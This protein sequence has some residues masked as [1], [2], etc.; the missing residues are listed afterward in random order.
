MINH[1]IFVVF[2]F[3]LLFYIIKKVKNKK[4]A[5]KES[6]IWIFSGCSVFLLAIFPQLLGMITILMGVAYAPTAL[7]LLTFFAIII[8]LLRKEEQITIINDKIKELAQRNAILEEKIRT[9]N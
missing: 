1:L 2:G 9:Q 3:L 7:F 6:L 8:I 5:E 4:F